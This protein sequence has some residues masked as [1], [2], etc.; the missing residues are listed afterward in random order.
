MGGDYA[1]RYL[2]PMHQVVPPQF[3]SR[4]DFDI[5]ADISER[6]GYR[7][8]FTEG[9]DERRWL[10]SI[11]ASAAT[12]AQRAKVPIPPFDTFWQ[13]GDYIEFPVPAEAK[14]FVR[15]S[16]FR[17]DPLLDAL[18]T[19]SGL[20]EIYSET[21]AKMNYADCGPHAR[22][23]EPDEWWNSAQAKQYP[24]GLVS[25][26]PAGRLHSQLSNTSLR[27]QYEVGKREPM[28]IHPD[29]ATPRGIRN[30]DIVRIRSA[31]GA[32]LAGAVVT[33]NIRPGHV[34]I[35]EG[36]WYDPAEPGK[37]GALCKHGSVNVLTKDQPTSSLASGNCGQS[38]IVQVEK[39]KGPPPPV[40]VFSAP[41]GAA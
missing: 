16:D 40:T 14:E 32:I 37:P 35:S 3:E 34:R 41:K 33:D 17:L 24:L 23:F 12:G 28:L 36:G 27:D 19:P 2:F 21:I 11:Y 4:N 7:D 13:S 6:L 5:F 39:F 38:G 20:I 1:A 31:H 8:K 22:W 15:F 25:S 9:K 10:Q 30:G 26:H 18:G 29:D